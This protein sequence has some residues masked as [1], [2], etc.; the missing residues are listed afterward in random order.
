MVERIRRMIRGPVF[1]HKSRER[2][3]GMINT[4]LLFSIGATFLYGL[5]VYFIAPNFSLSH[6]IVGLILLY[7]S[8]TWLINRRGHLATASLSL[9]IGLWLLFTLIFFLTGGIDNPGISAYLLVVVVAGLL[10]GGRASVVAAVGSFLTMTILYWLEITGKLPAQ[11]VPI[12][13]VLGSYLAVTTFLVVIAVLL[14]LTTQ[15]INLAFRQA[16]ENAAALQTANFKLQQEIEERNQVAAA[17]RESEARNRILVENAPDAILVYDAA[18]NHYVDA[19]QSAI[20]LLGLSHAQLLTIG[21][22]QFSPDQQPDGRPSATITQAYITQTLNGETPVFEWWLYDHQ[23]ILIPCEVRLVRLPAAQ[24][25]LIRCSVVDIRERKR[26]EEQQRTEQERL[27]QIIEAIPVAVIIS[28]RDA[29]RKILWSNQ[30][31][32]RYAGASIE[33]LIGQSTFDYYVEERAVLD[34]TR[35]TQEEQALYNYEIRLRNAQGIES[36]NRVSIVPFTYQGQPAHL[37]ILINT[38]KLKEVEEALRESE[39]RFRIFV[40][41]S[42]SGIVISSNGIIMDV[43]ESFARMFG[44]SRAEMIGLTPVETQTSESAQRVLAHIAARKEGPI[45]AVGLRKDGTTFPVEIVAKNTI[46]EGKPARLGAVNDLTEKKRSEEMLRQT[47]KMESLGLLAGGIAHD[48]NNLLVAILGQTSVALAK[49]EQ[50]E[51]ARPHIEKVK[52]AAERAASLTH[53]LLAYSG[54]GQFNIQPIQLNQLIQDNIHF[55]EVALPSHVRLETHLNETL[56][57]IE[58]D[59]GQMQQV[60]M[61]LVINGAEAINGKQGIVRLTT[62]TMQLD[63]SEIEYW[64][65]T[66]S[67]LTPGPYVGLQVQ[68][69]GSGMSAELLNR[70]FDPFFSTKATGRGLGLAAV[71]GIIRGHQGG[72]VVTSQPGHGTCYRLI[73]PALPVVPTLPEQPS[74]AF[75]TKQHA[76]TILVIDDEEWVREAVQDILTIE[77]FH[78]YAA[79]DGQAGL[80]LF[81]HHQNSIHLVLLDLAMPGLSGQQTYQAL[82]A[83]DPQVKI[84]L[85]SGYDESDVA[86]MLARD[87]LTRF[88]QKPYDLAQLTQHL[89]FLLQL[90]E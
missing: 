22:L 76:E 52:K 18:T 38:Q 56:P 45:E 16:Y 7:L 14:Y 37:S 80:N 89:S 65:R 4:I 83:L 78:V 54:G 48:F 77:G 23:G 88:L 81:R 50:G 85:S 13:P 75:S 59:A 17:L 63:G 33:T 49:M 30:T 31:G 9:T 40:E 41:T 70:I 86:A 6:R 29:H 19:N 64:Q 3:R 69:D 71:L 90:R 35:L 61:N 60:L 84:V 44:Y 42:F 36:W 39:E 27:Q 53:Q 55:F 51:G 47:Q 66:S 74:P 79:A 32:A 67:P 26:A 87:P 1:M 68:D 8:L 25:R 43:N 46:Y 82:R 20:E 28:T 24:Q 62:Y 73:F 57:L 12:P 10:L 5:A 58:A 72:V 11:M 21:P 2:L 34:I 15:S